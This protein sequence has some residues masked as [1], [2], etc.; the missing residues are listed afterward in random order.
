MSELYSFKEI[1]G[2]AIEIKKGNEKIWIFQSDNNLTEKE[3]NIITKLAKDDK[4]IESLK[5]AVN[6]ENQAIL[7]SFIKNDFWS[8]YRK[9][10]IKALQYKFNLNPD[11]KFSK[12]LFFAVIDFQKT[13]WITPNWIPDKNFFKKIDQN[14]FDIVEKQQK[15][16]EEKNLIKKTKENSLSKEAVSSYL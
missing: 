6:Q 11:W 15:I 13:N 10:Q 8:K 2:N 9:D 5:N 3:E 12:E 16:E 1:S 7:N 14:K 4:W